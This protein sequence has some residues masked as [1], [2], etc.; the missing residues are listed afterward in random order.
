MLVG[1]T[2]LYFHTLLHGMA[3]IPPIP[4]ELTAS[5]LARAEAEGTERLHAE[6]A[7]VDAEYAARIHPRDRQ[8]I[9]RA[10]EV[11]LG[12]GH[13]FTWWH[14][15]AACSPS[16]AGPLLVLSA[17]LA[18]LEPRLARRLDGMIAAGALEEAR[19]AMQ[20]CADP[21]APGWSGIG[22]HEVL[23]FV[24][25]R[26]TW[27]ACKERWLHNTRA[28]AKRQITWFRARSE[29]IFLPAEDIGAAVAVAAD[30]WN[31]RHQG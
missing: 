17:S 12:T 26:L 15:N 3:A 22:C 10:L 4:A 11:L 8:R 18:W 5:L 2:G 31:R 28:Y 29:A 13:T 16:C 19:R 1:G 6:L 30:C 24:Q 25:G 23:D 9:V 21:A 7:C 14:R 20:H 27:D